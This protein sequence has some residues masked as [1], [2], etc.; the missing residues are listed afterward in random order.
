[1]DDDVERV[2]GDFRRLAEKNRE[3]RNRE[4]AAVYEDAANH[5]ERVLG[6]A[7]SNG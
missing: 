4:A 7:D 1:M 5:V 6:E 3:E 2:I